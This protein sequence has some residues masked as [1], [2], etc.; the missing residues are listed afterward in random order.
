MNSLINY[1]PS[2]VASQVTSATTDEELFSYFLD[3]EDAAS[4]QNN[5]FTDLVKFFHQIP[6]N[7]LESHIKL[8]ELIVVEFN[9]VYSSE[10]ISTETSEDIRQIF[11]QNFSWFEQHNIFK[12][13]D[14]NARVVINNKAILVNKLKICAQSEFL[15]KIDLNSSTTAVGELKLDLPHPE[16]G[17]KIVK[18]LQTG[19]FKNTKK[20]EKALNLVL[21][22]NDLEI[23]PSI[24]EKI[25]G[26]FIELLDKN[27]LLE[28]YLFTKQH[29][30]ATLEK[31]C[32]QLI[33]SLS[34]S[35]LGKFW[36]SL[37][38]I[39]TDGL[40]LSEIRQSC[41]DA[42]VNL[43]IDLIK[44]KGPLKGFRAKIKM[45]CLKPILQH[46]VKIIS[47][48]K[49]CELSNNQLIK[50]FNLVSRDFYEFE[51]DQTKIQSLSPFTKLVNLSSLTLTNAPKF[52]SLGGASKLTHIKHLNLSGCLALESIE[53]VA[54]SFKQLKTIDLT[55]CVLLKNLAVLENCPNLEKVIIKNAELETIQSLRHIFNHCHIVTA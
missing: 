20:V 45:S 55:G 24:Q 12:I 37:D 49:V 27:T 48:R 5:N 15:A 41:I 11:K 6:K 19:V 23:C 47:N 7:A 34:V 16:A 52:Y 13:L 2:R 1:L 26:N 44:K 36:D 32:L 22:A 14:P 35:D 25:E 38:S 4:S 31:S 21:E 29:Q 8:T 28:F 42:S 40:D 18:A 33:S 9:S 50:L 51:V 46:C 39:Q 54:T 30:I 17:R 3:N 53:E 43:A 10:K